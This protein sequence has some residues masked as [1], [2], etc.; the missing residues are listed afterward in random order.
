MNCYARDTVNPVKGKTMHDLH[1]DTAREATY[2]RDHG[3]NIVEVWECQI[4]RELERDEEMKE[5]FEQY[6][7]TDTLEP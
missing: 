2:L 1:Q 6:E 4:G 7:M 3:F 5:Y